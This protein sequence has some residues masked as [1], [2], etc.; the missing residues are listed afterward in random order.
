[1][2]R[3]SSDRILIAL[4]PDSLALLRVSG[5]L[6][7]RVSEKRTVA[8]D[9]AFGA[10]PWQ[11]AVAALEQVAEETR[12]TNA[13]VTVV[14]SNH[15]AR[16]ILVPWSEG[17]KNAEEETAFVRYCFAKVH[18]E[19]SKEWDLRLSPTPTGSARIA[20]AIDSSLVQAVRAAFPAAAR[21][22]LVSVQPYLM[23]AFNRWR[24]D[25]K[26]ERV[27]FLLVE[28]QR[29]CL[30]RLE[31]GRWSVVRNAR[32][33]FDEPRQWAGLLDRERHR[34]GGDEA[35]EG[36][37]VHAPRNGNALPVEGEEWSFRS[38][39]LAPAEGL[40][41]AESQPFAMALCAL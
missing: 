12:H 23:S 11:G 30:A 34:V 40:A 29:A 21:A 24:K 28:P 25:I 10:Q 14:L 3:L 19:R 26:G 31:G 39:A 38:L 2:L 7:P 16:F 33:T 9:P 13:K 5:G 36:V 41:P 27:W 17:L 22:K 15:F 18:G 8:C 32:G 4:A 35:S 6:R 20:S 37:Y 1:V